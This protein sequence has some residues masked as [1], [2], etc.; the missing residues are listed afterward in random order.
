MRG[1][2][3]SRAFRP[4]EDLHGHR[5]AAAR[6]APRFQ[7]CQDRLPCIVRHASARR[8]AAPF[9]GVGRRLLHVLAGRGDARGAAVADEAERTR[10]G[11]VRCR[12][13]PAPPGVVRGPGRRSAHR[14]RAGRRAGTYGASCPPAAGGAGGVGCPCA[15]RGGSRPEPTRRRSDGS[16]SPGEKGVIDLY[17]TGGR[18]RSG[19]WRCAVSSA[20]A[21]RCAA[22]G[23]RGDPCRV[24]RSRDRAAAGCH[25]FGQNGNL[26][27]LRCRGAGPGRTSAAARAGDRSHGPVGR[28][29][30]AGFRRA[31]DRLS[32]ETHRPQAYGALPPPA[33][34]CGRRA[35]DRGPFG[36]LPAA[37]PP[38]AGRGGRGTRSQL[39]TDRPGAPLSGTRLRRADDPTAGVPYAAGQRYSVAGE[40]SKR[41]DRKIRQRGTSRAL[42]T[43]ADAA[44]PR[45]RYDPCR[46][47]RRAA[48]PF[49]Q[50]A[51]RPYGGDPRRRRSGDAFPEPAGFRT[52]CRVPGVRLDG[53]LSGL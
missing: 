29:A 46:E 27:A 49:Q 24:C 16:R 38:G 3:R 47:T 17:R 37:A 2:G 18:T 35:G 6:P 21:F 13:V 31:G 53:P 34:F 45:V 40:L 36:D 12:R 33:G 42:R 1:D 20:D 23:C 10:R 15:R 30:P 50:I 9:L 52:L 25:R 11:G 22:E 44:D 5:L 28:S 19:D 43:V 39:Q 48:C 14:R 4:I 51:A 32:F 26:Y 8:A 41:C 7:D